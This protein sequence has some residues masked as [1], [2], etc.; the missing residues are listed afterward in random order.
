MLAM[1]FLI[2]LGVLAIVVAGLVLLAGLLGAA[3]VIITFVRQKR[4]ERIDRDQ[5]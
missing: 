5:S 2:V 1:G 3:I 4:R